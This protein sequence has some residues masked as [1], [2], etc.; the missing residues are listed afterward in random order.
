M[1][2]NQFISSSGFCSR[3]KADA[4]IK[5]GKVTV[6]GQLIALGQVIDE[7][8]RVE[9]DGQRIA[10]KQRD[11]YV[12]LNKP[13]GIICTAASHIGDI[14]DFVNYQNVFSCRTAR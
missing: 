14:I 11:I 1:R 5:E 10:A 3:R 6:N 7:G 2:L 9:V 13:R 4:L 8:D 12:M